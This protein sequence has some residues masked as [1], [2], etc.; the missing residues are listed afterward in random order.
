MAAERLPMRKLREIIR[1]KLQAGLSGR[2]I[3]RSCN[4]S[5]GTVSGYLGRA[6][7]AKLS[8]P[9]GP[10]LDDD[11]ALSALLFP[12][13]AHPQPSRPEPDFVWVHQ[14][15]R[16]KHVT[17][18]LLWQEYR[19]AEP[20]GYG[21]SQFCERYARW[22][23]HLSATMRQAHRAGDDLP[24]LQFRVGEGRPRI[25]DGLVVILGQGP[26]HGWAP[27]RERRLWHQPI[28]CTKAGHIG[29]IRGVVRHQGQIVGESDR[30]D[31]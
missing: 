9:L 27:Q 22:A 5:P 21:Y 15:L 25:L 16:R 24:A 10:E 28:G 19:E 8:W 3:A 11:A 29:I 2:A 6:A 18:L 30:S 4:L 12:A 31:H 23:R 17:K 20:E 13:E 1:L 26:G 7:L 14:E